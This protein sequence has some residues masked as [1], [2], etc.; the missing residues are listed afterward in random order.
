MKKYLLIPMLL[1]V[2]FSVFA[3]EYIIG[4]GTS[5][6]YYVPFY[7]L[8]DYSWSKT[9]YTKA[10]INEAGLTSAGNI[11]AISYYVGNTPSNYLM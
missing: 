1:L 7:G 10:E 9:I 3:S 6:Q 5:T 11:D 8:Y 2:V 4:T